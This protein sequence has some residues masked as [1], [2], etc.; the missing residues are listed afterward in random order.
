MNQ[1]LF[2]SEQITPS[3]VV[4]I[5]R[6]YVDHAKELNND[7]PDSPV[8]FIKPN[9]AICG[10]LHAGTDQALHYEGEIALLIMD[11]A[12]TGV[13]FGLDL[14]NREIQNQLKA[15]G[16][17]WERAKAFDGAAVFSQFVRLSEPLESLSLEL[18]INDKLVQQGGY[19][20]MI[21][22]PEF[23][24]REISRSFTLEDGD[25][26]LTGTPKGVG[27][28][29]RGDRFQG[30]ILAANRPLVTQEWTAL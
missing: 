19:G 18:L 21:F 10:E 12:I 2:E 24:L 20:L 25:I 27:A 1:I 3:K 8:I 13:G 26:I 28:F 6:N 29:Q 22:K 23:L 11:G 5:G 7:V 14:T 16:L 15:K 9:S 4:C 17:P 30:T